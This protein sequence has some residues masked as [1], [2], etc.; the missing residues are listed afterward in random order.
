MSRSWMDGIERTS[1]VVTLSGPQVESRGVLVN[2][3][4]G[5]I[6]I[7]SEKD[8][9]LDLSERFQGVVAPST[10]KSFVLVGAAS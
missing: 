6:M 7:W 1:A 3:S 9:D 10:F 5:G 8:T 2:R 4:N